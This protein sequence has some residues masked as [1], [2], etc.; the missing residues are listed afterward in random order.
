MSNNC[1]VPTME[2]ISKPELAQLLLISTRTVDY[3]VRIGRLPKPG[4]LGRRA[5]WK[6]D[7][8][9]RVIAAAFPKG[10]GHV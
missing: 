6:R 7:E 1:D 8:I 10:D 3:W 2:I 4:Y 9:D 5:I